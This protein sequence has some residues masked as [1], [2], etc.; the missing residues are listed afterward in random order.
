MTACL[1]RRDRADGFGYLAARRCRRTSGSRSGACWSAGSGTRARSCATRCSSSAARPT[2]SRPGVHRDHGLELRRARDRDG[3]GRAA[4]RRGRARW[5]GSP[6]RS[7]AVASVVAAATPATRTRATRRAFE[8]RSSPRGRVPSRKRLWSL[9]PSTRTHGS[10]AEWTRETLA[11]G[12][13]AGRPAGARPRDHA[14]RGR[15]P[16][17][18]TSSSMISTRRRARRT[19]SASPARPG[20]ASRA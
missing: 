11:A 10:A 2:P 6:A 13:R 19:R 5:V 17:R 14:R 4:R 20:S 15:R 3:A 1:R 8:Q 16:A 12:V 7:P 9:R 18:R